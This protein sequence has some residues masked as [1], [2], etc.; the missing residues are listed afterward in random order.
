MDV[1]AAKTAAAVT[2]KSSSKKNRIS[3]RRKTSKIV[4]PKYADKNKA[5][6]GKK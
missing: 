1:D 6:K 3:K 4:F 2:S 5:K